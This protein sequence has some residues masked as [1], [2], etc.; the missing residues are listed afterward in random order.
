MAREVILSDE[1][2][3]LV[4]TSDDGSRWVQ[5]EDYITLL[6]SARQSEAALD[7]VD[8]VNG[9]DGD[10]T[11]ESCPHAERAQKFMWQVRDTCARAE[12]AET[13][14]TTLRARIADLEAQAQ[15]RGGETVGADE[16]AWRVCRVIKGQCQ[17]CPAEEMM[18][19]EMCKRSCR[20]QAEEAVNTVQTGNPW[21]KANSNWSSKDPGHE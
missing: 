8:R 13:E 1:T 12:R 5:E 19:G 14:L 15:A 9:C 6:A 21:R 20:L 18:G 7:A 16:L 2:S 3:P 11:H 17:R 10:F 4:A